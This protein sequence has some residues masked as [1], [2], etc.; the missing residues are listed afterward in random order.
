MYHKVL[1]LIEIKIIL[2]QFP[3][4]KLST[5]EGKGDPILHAHA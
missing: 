5:S 4:K 1:K 2:L 3:V